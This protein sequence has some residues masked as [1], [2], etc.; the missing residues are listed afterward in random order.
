M[1][2]SGGV[3][4]QPKESGMPEVSLQFFAQMLVLGAAVGIVSNALGVGGGLLIVPALVEFAPGIDQHTA[5]GT[6]LFII[7]FVALINAWRLNRGVTHIE[8]RLT[9]LLAAGSIV[10]GY[11]GAWGTILLPE[12]AVTWIFVTVLV[13]LALRLAFG[14]SGDP[15]RLPQQAKPRTAILIGLATGIISGATGVGGG[16]IMV[17]LV[18]LAAAASHKRVAAISN[19]VMVMTCLAA[20]VAHAQAEPTSDLPWTWGQINVALAPLIVAG[21]QTAGPLGRWINH[22]LTRTQRRRTMLV[23]LTLIAVRLLYRTIT[24]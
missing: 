4:S 9:A 19:M 21:A 15:E 5:K 7:M 14:E 10:G 22:N 12:D 6:S 3:Y 8:W 20:T 13:L 11:G 2:A 1:A 17:P 23:L 24:A 16:A 18:L